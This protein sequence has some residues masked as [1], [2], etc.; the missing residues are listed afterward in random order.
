MH[1]K[2]TLHLKTSKQSFILRFTSPQDLDR[3]LFDGPWVLDDDVLA[4]D[5][6]TPKF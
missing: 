2:K 1:A 4:L 5:Q 3:V 6:W